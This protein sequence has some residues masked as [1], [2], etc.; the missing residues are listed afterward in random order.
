MNI[1]ERIKMKVGTNN[2][3]VFR[4]SFG[5]VNAIMV[6]WIFVGIAIKGSSTFIEPNLFVLYAELVAS[7]FILGIIVV[8]FV[9]YL[10]KPNP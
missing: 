6:V 7:V 3:E 10:R 9:E 1:I 2:I 4:R 5:L 8:D